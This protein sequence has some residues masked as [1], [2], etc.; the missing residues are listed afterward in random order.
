MCGIAGL[1]RSDDR[2]DLGRLQ[3]MSRLLR[4]RGPDDEGIV[5]IDPASGAALP[6]GGPDTPRDVYTIATRY[7]PGR[8]PLD[9]DAGAFRVGWRTGGRDRRLDTTGHGPMCDADARC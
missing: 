7:S 8:H 1:Y 6:L 3:H 2:V 9:P 5:L 4:H